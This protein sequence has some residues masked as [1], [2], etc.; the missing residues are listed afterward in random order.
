MEPRAQLHP[1]WRPCA[2][3]CLDIVIELGTWGEQRH[4]LG[5]II[6]CVRWTTGS[7]QAA[8]C[9]HSTRPMEYTQSNH[10][11]SFGHGEDLPVSHSVCGNRGGHVV[12]RD[13]TLSTEEHAQSK[14][15]GHNSRYYQINV[16]CTSTVRESE[17]LLLRW[18]QQQNGA[19]ISSGRPGIEGSKNRCFTGESVLSLCKHFNGCSIQFKDVRSEE[20]QG[21]WSGGEVREWGIGERARDK[22]G[23]EGLWADKKRACSISPQLKIVQSTELDA[24]NKNARMEELLKK[25]GE[26][27]GE[28]GGLGGSKRAGV[29][30]P[31]ESTVTPAIEPSDLRT[32]WGGYVARHSAQN[33]LARAQVCV[34]APGPHKIG[35]RSSHR[36]GLTALTTTDW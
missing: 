11:E 13:K 33:S 22:C 8:S 31:K 36:L 27:E 26:L 2:F 24:A 12:E 23:D 35:P 5:Q 28:R 9:H 30:E 17:V 3:P 14:G 32:S 6:P 25:E 4:V 18:W 34:I 16:S 10:A 7:G 20:T 29:G 15:G 21:R 19:W 1:G